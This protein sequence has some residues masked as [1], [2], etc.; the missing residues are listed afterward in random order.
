MRVSPAK[1]CVSDFVIQCVEYGVQFVFIPFMD[2]TSFRPSTP[3]NAADSI[4][5]L[6]RVRHRDIALT[7]WSSFVFYT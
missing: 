4:P 1:K 2:H 5:S 7:L 6:V 3:A